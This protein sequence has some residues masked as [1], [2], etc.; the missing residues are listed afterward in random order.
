MKQMWTSTWLLKL[1]QLMRSVFV[2][3]TWLNMFTSRVSCI[4]LWLHKSLFHQLLCVISGTQ[5]AASFLWVCCCL[6]CVEPVR[7]VFLEVAQQWTELCDCPGLCPLA[8][9]YSLV[10]IWILSSLVIAFTHPVMF[11]LLAFINLYINVYPY[12]WKMFHRLNAVLV[13]SVF[14]LFVGC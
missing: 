5:G 8:T 10:L 13:F 11:P 3:K 2:H 4:L 1:M 7:V 14:V 12:M 9:S 6:P